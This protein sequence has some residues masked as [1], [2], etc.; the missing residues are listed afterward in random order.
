M[1][2]FTT[3]AERYLEIWNTTD[4]GKR[5]ALVEEVFTPGATY[6][7]PLGA[8][9]GW[10]GID[11]FVAGAQEQFGGLPVRLGGSVD[12]H[13]NIARFQWHLGPHGA[14]EPVA[15]GFDV[16]VA[17]DDRISSVYGFLDKVPG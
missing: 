13:H 11:G 16:I 5:R 1:S 8:V 4:A 9:S 15:I 6:T 2:E 7:D 14:G 3:L 17:E 10:D 12:G